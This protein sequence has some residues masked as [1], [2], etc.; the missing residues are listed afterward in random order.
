MEGKDLKAWRNANQMTQDKAADF[1][2]ISRSQY[3]NYEAGR[4]AIP[5]GL[6]DGKAADAEPKPVIEK[7]AEQAKAE[8]R[9]IPPA[10][11][12]KGA[13]RPMAREIREFPNRFSGPDVWVVD[14]NPPDKLPGGQIIRQTIIKG[15]ASGLGDY[16]IHLVGRGSG[17]RL[18]KDCLPPG[19]YHPF[20]PATGVPL[21]PRGPKGGQ[22]KAA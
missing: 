12:M 2:G 20:T 18:D 17:R 5:P 10:H 9:E 6:I 7:I 13:R 8:L 16:S 22:K 1:L 21:D 15:P 19:G 4:R 14:H 3:A 11:I